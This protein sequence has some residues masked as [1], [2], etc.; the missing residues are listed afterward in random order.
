MA[1][2]RGRPRSLT[3]LL[4]GWLERRITAAME[5]VRRREQEEE[6]REVAAHVAAI[7]NGPV[8]PTH[9]VNG[10]PIDEGVR[11]CGC[12]VTTFGRRA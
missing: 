8:E 11:H 12:P 4:N 2:R 7:L 6:Q 10:H 3:A 5:E 9:C 1:E